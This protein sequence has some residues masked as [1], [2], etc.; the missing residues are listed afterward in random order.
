MFEGY[1][2]GKVN[3]TSAGQDFFLQFGLTFNPA[4]P[5]A[6]E[7]TEFGVTQVSNQYNGIDDQSFEYRCTFRVISQTNTR[8]N[9]VFNTSAQISTSNGNSVLPNF[10]ANN[11][12]G[13]TG[14]LIT[15]D[16]TIDG[17]IRLAFFGASLLDPEQINF[18]RYTS[19]IR[20]LL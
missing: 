18:Y 7:G 13:V 5:D 19:Y 12:S 1:Y 14:A 3:N 11:S 16:R 10:G 2:S 6:A 4:A 9:I 15:R 8:I 20:K 17:T